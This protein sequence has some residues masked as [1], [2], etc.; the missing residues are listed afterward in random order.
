MDDISVSSQTTANDETRQVKRALNIFEK[1]VNGLGQR[2]FSLMQSIKYT[3]DHLASPSSTVVRGLHNLSA[4][5][6]KFQN[7]RHFGKLSKL[8]ECS[9]T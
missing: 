9:F 7:I 2:Q 4:Y 3:I 1:Y 6:I 5:Q 8:K